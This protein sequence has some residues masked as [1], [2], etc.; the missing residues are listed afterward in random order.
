MSL[1]IKIHK[2]FKFVGLCGAQFVF[3]LDYDSIGSSLFPWTK[4]C[5]GFGNAALGKTFGPF[6][7]HRESFVWGK[8]IVVLDQGFRLC[9]LR[10]RNIVLPHLIYFPKNSKLLQLYG[11]R[12][13]ADPHNF[14]LLCA[15]LVYVLFISIFFSFHKSGNKCKFP[16]K[17]SY[18]FKHKQLKTSTNCDGSNLEVL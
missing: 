11:C 16:T 8:N 3:D 12:Q 2:I 9:C 17:L 7:S 14:L 4:P 13:I 18:H 1:T 5:Q 15:Y 6:L 10:V